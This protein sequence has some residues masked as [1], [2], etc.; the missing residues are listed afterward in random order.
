MPERPPTETSRRRDLTLLA[1]A[2]VIAL[3]IVTVLVVRHQDSGTAGSATSTATSAAAAAPAAAPL[4][5]LGDLARRQPNDPMAQGSVTAPVTFVEFADFRCPFCAQFARTTEPQLVDKYVNSGVLR[6]EWRDMPIFGD[7][8]MAAA[9][10]G[11]AA[12][13]QGRFWPFVDAVYHAAPPKG[14]ADLTPAAL[15]GFAEQA[16]VPDLQRFTADAT[17]TTFDAAIDADLQVANRFGISSTPA[18]SVHGTPVLGAQPTE[19]FTTLIDNLAAGRPAG[20]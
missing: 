15:R 12:A 13:A 10:A 20:S 17:S 16:G 7:Q 18:F 2:I 6:I 1:V 14:H 19:V 8:S 3:I 4:G 11:R 9:R 5:P